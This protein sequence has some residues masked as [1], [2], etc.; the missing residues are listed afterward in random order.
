[1]LVYSVN[2]VF[3]KMDDYCWLQNL[4]AFF[5]ALMPSFIWPLI[6]KNLLVNFKVLVSLEITVD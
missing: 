1:M 3:N 6:S 4:V 2:V 5:I